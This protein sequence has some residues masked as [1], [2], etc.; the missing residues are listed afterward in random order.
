MIRVQSLEENKEQGCWVPRQW[1]FPPCPQ[2]VSGAL[3][4]LP[5]PTSVQFSKTLPCPSALTLTLGC[6]R[7]EQ[8]D[9]QG[10]PLLLHNTVPL[11]IP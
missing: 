2:Y 11:G 6:Q 7:R 5:T 8:R 4:S 1:L 3:P 9:G 10:P